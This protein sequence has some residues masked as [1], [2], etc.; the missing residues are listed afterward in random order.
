[1]MQ[2]Q[3]SC[4]AVLI[5]IS[6]CILALISAF[7]PH[8]NNGYL[9][10]VSV[11]LVGVSPY[12][13]Y[14]IAMPYLRSSLLIIP[15]LLLI[16]AHAWL[17]LSYRYAQTVDYSDHWIY[18]GPLL[19]AVAVLPLLYFAMRVPYAGHIKPKADAKTP[20]E[21]QDVADSGE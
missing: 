6:G 3:C 1:M 17:V 10:M 20:V 8:Y 14:A 19:L 12:I 2:K 11:L 5:I 4:S 9:L 13:V 18:Y 7:V 15:G 16:V 21:Q